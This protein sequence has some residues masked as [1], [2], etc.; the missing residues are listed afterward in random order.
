MLSDSAYPE[1]KFRVLTLKV[2]DTRY[3]KKEILNH[4]W[5]E[6][7]IFIHMSKHNLEYVNL[8]NNLKRYGVKSAKSFQRIG[9]SGRILRRRWGSY[10][11]NK[12][13]WYIWAQFCFSSI[14]G[15]FWKS[16]VRLFFRILF[17][18]DQKEDD[19]V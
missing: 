11:W 1:K 15:I 18:Q 14:C 7:L 12:V 5:F 17:S 9:N 2:T 19:Q 8:I 13:R 4:C 3:S 16:R 10:P 6:S